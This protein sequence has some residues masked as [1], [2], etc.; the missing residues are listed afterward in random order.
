MSANMNKKQAGAPS[1][2]QASVNGGLP[3][4]EADSAHTRRIAQS[5]VI[6]CYLLWGLMPLYWAF[7]PAM[8]SFEIVLHR[9][10]WTT[11]FTLAIVIFKK[12]LKETFTLLMDRRNMAVVFLCGLM[13]VFNN[14]IYIWAVTN[15]QVIEAGVGYFLTP[16]LQMAVGIILLKDK[17]TRLQ[18]LSILLAATGLIVQVVLLG[19][20]P[21]VAIGLSLTFGGYTIVKKYARYSTVPGFFWETALF[22]PITVTAIIWLELGGNGHAETFF[23]LLMLMGTGPLTTLPLIW[24]SFGARHLSLISISLMQYLAPTMVLALGIFWFKEE[25]P[26]AQIISF[27]FILAALVIYTLESVISFR[28]AER[29]NKAQDDRENT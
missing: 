9:I 17:T 24:F 14:L 2:N 15:A 12:Q 5:G 26:A 20:L 29:D 22:T 6:A 16:L 27:P 19:K 7:I 23:A 11:L 10:S 18:K 21:L 28:R 13:M 3:S 25:L 1:V 4:F 8:P